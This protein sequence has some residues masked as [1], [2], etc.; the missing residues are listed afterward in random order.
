MTRLALCLAILFTMNA[1]TAH[2]QQVRA[3]TLV[4]H[5]AFDRSAIR[6]GDSA[7]LSNLATRTPDSTLLLG[8]TDTTG[9]NAYN[10]KLSYRRALAAK[11]LLQPQ[12]P[13]RL[14][15]RGEADPLPGADSLSRRTLLIIYYHI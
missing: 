1:R 2:A 6:S 15:G 8:Y 11:A 13:P 5:F 3:D 14:E 4:V 9:S 10:D 12:I 7:V